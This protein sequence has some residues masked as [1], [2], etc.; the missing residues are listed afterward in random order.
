MSKNLKKNK[1]VLKYLSK[2]RP[3]IV[4]TFIRSADLGLVNA[5]SECCLNV[6][7]GNVPLN[8]KQKNRL[9]NYK[10]QLRLLVKKKR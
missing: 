5:I 1:E 4:K 9:R 6:L 3:T 8:S 7:K 2:A 10:N